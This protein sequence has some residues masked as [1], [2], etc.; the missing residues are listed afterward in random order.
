MRWKVKLLENVS[1]YRDVEVEADSE[2]EAKELALIGE[3]ADEGPVYN[4]EVVE[5]FVEE[6]GPRPKPLTDY[7][8]IRCPNCGEEEP[9]TVA[10]DVTLY[11]EDGFEFNGT[12]DEKGEPDKQAV[13]CY[14]PCGYYHPVSEAWASVLIKSACAR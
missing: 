3:T 13:R 5:R 7:P 9:W 10:V 2:D 14:C 4:A 12:F 8:N 1:H 6:I 11:N